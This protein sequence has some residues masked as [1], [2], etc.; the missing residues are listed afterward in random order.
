VTSGRLAVVGLGPGAPAWRSPEATA[1]LCTATDL[2]GYGPY[3]EQVGPLDP[4]PRRHASDNREELDRADHAFELASEGRDVVVVSSGDPGVFA[5]ATAVLERLETRTTLAAP[6]V[7]VTIV[8]GITA[9]SAAAARVGAPLGHDFCCLSLSDVRKP[10]EVVER[11]LVAVAAADL[12]IALYNP[13]S[14]A[15]PWQFG[16][17]MELLRAHR[18]GPTPVVLGRDVGRPGETVRVTTL[19]EL[20]LTAVDMRTIVIVGSSTTRTFVDGEGRRWVYTPR[21]YPA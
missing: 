7:D 9:A 14:R 8:P 12:V 16:R 13:A 10:W 18:A 3:L 21:D 2:V 20:D 1:R 11:R 6:A 17:A 15:R 19:E 4:E 5:M